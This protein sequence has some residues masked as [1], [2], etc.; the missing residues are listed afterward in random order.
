MRWFVERN[1]GVPNGRHKSGAGPLVM[2]LLLHYK[3]VRKYCYLVVIGLH[4]SK[5]RLRFLYP[6]FGKGVTETSRSVFEA[7]HRV[8][9]PFGRW[10]SGR[11]SDNVYSWPEETCEGYCASN[12]G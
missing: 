3:L 9:E 11:S 6:L 10:I 4:N 2:Y 8:G 5:G 12:L 7:V 1:E